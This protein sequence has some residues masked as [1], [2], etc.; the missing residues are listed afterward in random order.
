M[1]T[2]NFEAVEKKSNLV[3]AE[4]YQS[5]VRLRRDDSYNR[6]YFCNCISW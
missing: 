4:A 5:Q 3:K 1:E 2:Q 6:R